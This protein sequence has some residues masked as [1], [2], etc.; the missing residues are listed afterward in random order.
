MPALGTMRVRGVIAPAPWPGVAVLALSAL[1]TVVATHEALHSVHHI[2]GDD[3]AA[4]CQFE[5]TAGNVVALVAGVQID[6]APL[7]RAAFATLP[8]ATDLH[9]CRPLGVAGGRAPPVPPSA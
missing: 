9:P 6:V 4:S 8:L 2:G 7:A 3:A 5:A 1:L